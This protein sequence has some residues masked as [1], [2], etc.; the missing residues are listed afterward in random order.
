LFKLLL[1]FLAQHF[2]H[3]PHSPLILPW[4][5]FAPLPCEQCQQGDRVMWLRFDFPWAA[6]LQLSSAW[7]PANPG[8]AG[9]S[10]CDGT[11][12]LKLSFVF[13]SNFLVRI[14]NAC[15]HLGDFETAEFLQWRLI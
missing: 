12:T 9:S 1:L 6:A 8:I 3:S 7:S 5:V 10:V 14:K 15:N 4:G 13:S 2:G 11:E